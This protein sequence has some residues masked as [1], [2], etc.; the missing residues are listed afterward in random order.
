M[1]QIIPKVLILT[2]WFPTKTRH[3]KEFSKGL[4]WVLDTPNCE[5]ELLLM[6]Y[7]HR[8]KETSL[9]CGMAHGENYALKNR[10]THILILEAD[11]LISPN[12][13][14]KMLTAKKQVVIGTLFTNS[15]NKS[16]LVPYSP[17]HGGWCCMLVETN[18][19]KCNSFADKRNRVKFGCDTAWLGNVSREGVEIFTY[20]GII[21]SVL[22]GPQCINK[23]PFDPGDFDYQMDL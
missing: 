8:L 22:E 3:F 16:T 20:N 11:I 23:S 4:N 21:K 13:L 2:T 1:K 12:G 15:K 18:V 9:L 19:L 7:F 14:E 10:F 6:C 17:H 5:K